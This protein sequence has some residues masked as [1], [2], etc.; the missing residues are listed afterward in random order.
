MTTPGFSLAVH[1]VTTTLPSDDD[2]TD[3]SNYSYTYADYDYTEYFVSN[4]TKFG[5]LP[6]A[7]HLL[8]HECVY[9]V[10]MSR[11]VFARAPK[12][13]VLRRSKGV[14]AIG[15][16]HLGILPMPIGRPRPR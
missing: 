5:Y 16:V 14:I 9:K 11:R 2:M 4:I 12:G 10:D 6:C 3:Y 15:P 8:C 13:R 1:S 7:I